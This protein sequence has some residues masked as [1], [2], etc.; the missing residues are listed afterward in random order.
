MRNKILL[1]FALF[2]VLNK[3]IVIARVYFDKRLAISIS[4]WENFEVRYN[5]R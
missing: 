3:N 2:T 4:T 1:L 5:D